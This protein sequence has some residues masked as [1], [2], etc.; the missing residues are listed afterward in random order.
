MP[1]TDHHKVSIRGMMKNQYHQGLLL[2][3]P[4]HP[5]GQ[6]L[7][8]KDTKKVNKMGPGV[9]PYRATCTTIRIMKRDP[10]A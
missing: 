2:C 7:I 1:G 5:T 6:L 10:V 8:L 9:D 3:P 4:L